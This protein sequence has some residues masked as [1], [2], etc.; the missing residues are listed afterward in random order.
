[1]IIT[2]SVGNEGGHPL[3]NFPSL[4]DKAISHLLSLYLNL[5][6]GIQETCLLL[7]N[8]FSVLIYCLAMPSE[9]ILSATRPPFPTYLLPSLSFSSPSV[10]FRRRQSSNASVFSAFSTSSLSTP[11][12]CG[13]TPNTTPGSSPP[14][15]GYFDQRHQSN[16][17]YTDSPPENPDKEEDGAYTG[18]RLSKVQPDTLK[19]ST[20]ATDLAYASQIVSKGFTGRHG[21]A[22]LVS[23]PLQKLSNTDPSLGYA[24]DDK[25]N[26]KDLINTKVGRPVNRQLVTGAHVVADISC[27]I[28]H[29]IVGWKYVDAKEIAQRY[30]IGKFILETR[31]VVSGKTWEEVDEADIDGHAFRVGK[32]SGNERGT[33]SNTEEVEFDS[34]DEDECE[35]L[36]AGVWDAEVVGKRRGRRV[37]AR[38]K[39]EDI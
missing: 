17:V 3:T 6:A 21:R 38:R 10:L 39:L 13:S 31:R 32:G 26:A 20:C 29:S 34:E 33:G 37:A 30:K 24:G 8:Y 16:Y 1:M 22:Y 4:E 7:S 12:S 5:L 23:A 2:H 28:C 14:D 11:L 35:D 18:A 15:Q 19:C 27:V 25:D 9:T 36:F